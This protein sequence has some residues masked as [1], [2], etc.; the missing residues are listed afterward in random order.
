[1]ITCKSINI[2]H[3]PDSQSLNC[4][5]FLVNRRHHSTGSVIGDKASFTYRHCFTEILYAKIALYN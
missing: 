1:M 3:T 4:S 5:H 2:K